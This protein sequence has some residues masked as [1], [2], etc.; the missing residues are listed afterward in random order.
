[1]KKTVISLILS[2]ALVL[3]G[4]HFDYI[5]YAY[6]RL[7]RMEVPDDIDPEESILVA[8]AEAYDVVAEGGVILKSR[9]PAHW[10]KLIVPDRG[11]F[12]RKAEPFRLTMDQKLPPTLQEQSYKLFASEYFAVII[13][14]GQHFL[15]PVALRFGSPGMSISVPAGKLVNLGDIYIYRRLW[16][17]VHKVVI[18]MAQDNAG[19]EAIEAFAAQYPRIYEAYK[20][21]IVSPKASVISRP[22]P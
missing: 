5:R 8:L 21:E 11:P 18:D 19:T 3:M 6:R 15:K 10:E 7:R 14:P 4:C 13:P 12:T 16:K 22:F 17:D 1:M 2:I 20:D 9:T